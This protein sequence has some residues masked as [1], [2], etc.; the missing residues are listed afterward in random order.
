MIDPFFGGGLVLA[1]LIKV[2]TKGWAD[3]QDAK[4][5]RRLAERVDPMNPHLHLIA[6]RQRMAR[7]R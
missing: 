7:R 2:T 3:V 1:A 6:G 4:A 5:R